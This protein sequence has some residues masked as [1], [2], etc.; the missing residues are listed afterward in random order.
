MHP[1]INFSDANKEETPPKMLPPKI[2]KG[3]KHN[4]L[5]IDEY[6]LLKKF[7]ATFFKN[8][9]TSMQNFIETSEP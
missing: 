1:D 8:D 5:D 3:L 2:Y 9:K 4:L 6:T 7:F